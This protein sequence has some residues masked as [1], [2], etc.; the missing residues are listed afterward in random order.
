M[1]P[2]KEPQ[3]RRCCFPREDLR[4]RSSGP[5]PSRQAS[6]VPCAFMTLVDF[7]HLRLRAHDSEFAHA[8]IE[9][10]S[11]KTETRG[12][13]GWTTNHPL[14][15]VQNFEYV[16]AFDSFECVAVRMNYSFRLLFQL[17]QRYLQRRAA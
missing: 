10:G 14:G 15:V 3:S 7:R 5:A 2:M 6:F 4:D 13:A 16:I 9:R 8:V 11:I 17:R 1:P 12:R